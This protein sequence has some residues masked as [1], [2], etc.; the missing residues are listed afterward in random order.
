MHIF[1]FQQFPFPARQPWGRF[2]R[3]PTSECARK[4]ESI[5][6][7][8][9]PTFPQNASKTYRVVQESL[10]SIAEAGCIKA[11]RI[12]R[13]VE[14]LREE[15]TS[16]SAAESCKE[17]PHSVN[18][19]TAT[20]SMPEFINTILQEVSFTSTS[21]AAWSGFGTVGHTD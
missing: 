3:F 6:P 16:I 19:D 17:K 2:Q 8:T 11:R 5:F 20:L 15:D 18:I 9:S 7:Q 1:R 14:L 13:A 12:E 10:L 21:Q 4:K